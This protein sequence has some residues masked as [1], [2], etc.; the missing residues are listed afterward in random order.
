MAWQPSWRT[1]P[2]RGPWFLFALL[3]AV[4]LLPTAGVLWFMGEAV[5]NERF[6]VRQRLS[7]AY[8]T[9]LAK[10]E[11]QIEALWRQR[12]SQLASQGRGAAAFA[13]CVEG[14]LADSVVIHDR[15]GELI[16]PAVATP[17][18]LSLGSLAT[19]WTAAEGLERLGRH[20]EAA[21]AWQDIAARAGTMHWIGRAL[22]A[23]L[24]SL[25]RLGE[26]D[27]AVE[28]VTGQ[29]AEPRLAGALDTQGRQIV[30]DAMLLAIDLLEQR[31]AERQEVIERLQQRLVS[32]DEP[33]LPAAQRRFLLRRLERIEALDAPAKTLL[34]AENLAADYL[35]QASVPAV[36]LR[37]E[38]SGLA[39]R[40]RLA[41]SDGSVVGLFEEVT[42]LA[43]LRLLTEGDDLPGG[44]VI[45]ILAPG[46]GEAAGEPFVS[47]SLSQGLEGW[48]LALYLEGEDSFE[49]ASR[50]QIAIYRGSGVLLLTAILVLSGWVVSRVAAQMRL[51]RLKGDLLSNVSH[52]LKT[53]L[54][55]TRLLVDTLLGDEQSAPART[56]EY[57]QL[58]AR[59]NERLSHL[60][61]SF[62]TFSRLE[63]GELRLT[64][65]PLDPRELVRSAAEA[66]E[67]RV[68]SAGG[69]MD[70]QLA[71]PLPRIEGD[72]DTLLSALLNLLDNACKFSPEG[73]RIVLRAE[74]ASGQVCLAVRDRGIGLA[75]RARRRVFERF[76]QADQRLSRQGGGCGLGLSIVRRIVAAHGGSVEVE[77]QLGQGSTFTIRL[78][79]AAVDAAD[80]PAT[81]A[82]EPPNPQE[83]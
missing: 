23:R 67:E 7:Q 3:S 17:T 83:T 41:S 46:G 76:Y 52:E 53:P 14:D 57:L 64:R 22:Q 34:D 12:A 8:Q 51:N 79:V 39:G 74:A 29:L 36:P 55:S 32:Y 62:L 73:P 25:A 40:W 33:I 18:P 43:E 63:R 42:V 54:A 82:A 78:P 65:R 49:T 20:D 13:R 24:R 75:P 80:Q 50:R 9:H 60:V 19:A 68:V 71:D 27:A 58:I 81:A 28:L 37:F 44:T 15:Q 56:R 1:D 77:S 30:P 16:Y 10:M 45:E 70:L 4:V 59:E 66:I 11:Q 6:A 47:R 48:R 69:T 2:S 35:A 38:P 5:R 31:P 26:I 61:E 72:R 21:E